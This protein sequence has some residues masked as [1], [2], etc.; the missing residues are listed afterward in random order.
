MVI[1]ILGATG[2]IG[3]TL[4][5]Y[6]DRWK[7]EIYQFAR[8]NSEY[9]K[10]DKFFDYRKYDCIIN[11]IGH[12]SIRDNYDYT[13][14]FEVSEEYDNLAIQYLKINRNCRYICFSSGSIFKW[15]DINYIKEQD[16]LSIVKRYQEAKHRSYKNL[17]IF[18]I[19]LYSYFSRWADLDQKYFMNNLVQALVNKETFYFNES[20]HQLVRD[21]IHPKDLF[22]F[23]ESLM[24]C[25]GNQ[26]YE[27]GSKRPIEL[28]KIISMYKR[29]GLQA[30]C[31]QDEF[32][33][34]SGS[35]LT[36]VPRKKDNIPQSTSLDT[37]IQ[38]VKYFENQL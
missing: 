29:E 20:I 7:Y 31:T 10:Y 5:N 36:Y 3:Q 24:E 17:N 28:S 35:K 13:K 2:Q 15:Y 11:C 4:V 30:K 1:A 23:V 12:G 21:Y 27:I 38:E 22:N 25:S 8:N 32:E 16:Y 34:L 37:I 18:D 19:R 9:Y 26:V 33:N 14:I 6:F